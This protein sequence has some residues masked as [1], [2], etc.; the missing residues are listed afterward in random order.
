V[1]HRAIAAL[2]MVLSFSRAWA[3]NS[4]HRV[5]SLQT[6]RAL[7]GQRQV[8][9]VFNER[10]HG[11][12]LR[13]WKR[14]SEVF[15]T[16]ADARL[17]SEQDILVS[18]ADSTMES[19]LLAE[20]GGK[21]AERAR[22]AIFLLCLRA[23]YVPHSEF[24]VKQV[25]GYFSS[26]DG[27]GRISP[28]PPDPS[29]LDTETRQA[30]RAA[31]SSPN[32]KL[33]SSTKIYTFALLEDLSSLPTTA[34]AQRWRVASGKVPACFHDR[35]LA[36]SDP[37]QVIPILKSA[38]ASRGLEAAAAISSLLRNERNP[39]TRGE[40][41]EMVRFLDSAAARLR[42]SEEG[43][44]VIQAVKDVVL[45]HSLQYCSM[46]SNNTDAE[47]RQYWRELEDQFLT[48]KFDGGAGSWSTVVAVAL[49]QEYGDHFSVPFEK[50]YRK[51][52]PQMQAL[53]SQLTEADPTFPAWEFPSTGTQDDVLHPLF[54]SKVRRYHEMWTKMN[55]SHFGA[56]PAGPGKLSKVRGGL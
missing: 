33:R 21:D 37:E 8:A 38:L 50:G 3:Q 29:K 4:D 9:V 15:L 46:R 27:E 32:A 18:S 55:T 1:G 51:S 40:E 35:H 2:L 42:R 20:T 23:R 19:A 44:Q 17:S 12:S 36:Y 52:G 28:F 6:F 26:A 48:D 47:R 54:A 53:L 30:I 13:F 45:T 24:F 49:D 7:S 16:E 5:E 34:L 10:F 31:L 43:R 56:V 25:N 39:E 41:I 22:Y 14:S 11:R